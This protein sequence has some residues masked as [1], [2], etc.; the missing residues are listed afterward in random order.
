MPFQFGF[1]GS[2]RRLYRKKMPA[3][4]PFAA[5]AVFRWLGSEME[6]CCEPAK[7]SLFFNLRPIRWFFDASDGPALGHSRDHGVRNRVDLAS[8]GMMA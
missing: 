6:P 2:Q 1:A 4:V 5:G 7:T 3:A 8:G